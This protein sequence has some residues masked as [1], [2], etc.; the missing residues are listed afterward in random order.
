MAKN[1][2]IKAYSLI[3]ISVV[4]V[5]VGILIAGV[6][7]GIDLFLETKLAIARNLTTSSRVGRISDLELWLDSISLKSFYKQPNHGDLISK[8]KDINP[9]SLYKL[10][11]FQDNSLY[12]PSYNYNSINGLPTLKFDDDCF[13]LDLDI[14]FNLKPNLTIFAVFKVNDKSSNAYNPLFGNDNGGWDNFFL[15]LHN[16]FDKISVSNGANFQIINFNTEKNMPYMLKYIS[17]HSK[18]NGSS[19]SYNQKLITS[20]T[21]NFTSNQNS[22]I[23]IGSDGNG[24]KGGCD[25][26]SKFDLGEFIIYDRVLLNTEISEIEEYLKKKW[27]IKI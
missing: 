3:E 6:S 20:F 18:T 23:N 12:Q 13:R 5:V 19:I 1:Y 9:T 4:I 21:Q 10:E 26:L 25:N 24:S 17:Q 16:G 2:K 22:Y 14:T 7:R 15:I 27:Q 8:W 11:A